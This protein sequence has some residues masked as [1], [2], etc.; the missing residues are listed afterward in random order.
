[1]AVCSDDWIL[2]SNVGTSCRDFDFKLVISLTFS[3]LPSL[4]LLLIAWLRFYH[5]LRCES[6][7][8]WCPKGKWRCFLPAKMMV[9]TLAVLSDA[10]V[11]IAWFCSVS[12]KSEYSRA[13]GAIIVIT[14]VA[15]VSAVLPMPSL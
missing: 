10:I 13:G 6:V 11:V 15:S 3:L 5:L 12:A 8:Q 14:F 2:S 4:V 7:V 9:F 1:M